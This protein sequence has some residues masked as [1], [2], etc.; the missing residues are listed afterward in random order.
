MQQRLQSNIIR[1]MILA[2]VMILGQGAV[3][4]GATDRSDAARIP[5]AA[6]GLAAFV[7]DAGNLVAPSAGAVWPAGPPPKAFGQFTYRT[8]PSGVVVGDLNGAWL[9]SME[10]SVA[11]DGSV[12]IGCVHP[13]GAP[14]A[15][16]SGCAHA[17]AA[18]EERNHE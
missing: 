13:G 10:A 7:D 8:L 18:S 14:H 16:S 1:L 12:N 9:V 4:S 11:E 3:E 5:G 2:L 15:H 17:A 6:S